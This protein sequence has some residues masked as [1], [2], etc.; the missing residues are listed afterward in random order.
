MSLGDDISLSLILF[1]YAKQKI[2]NKQSDLVII[3]Q[4]FMRK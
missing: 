1:L 3:L 4:L 2:K